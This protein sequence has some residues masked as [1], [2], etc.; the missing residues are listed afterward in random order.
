MDASQLFER[1][2]SWEKRQSLVGAVVGLAIVQEREKAFSRRRKL[3][4]ENEAQMLK[5]PNQISDGPVTYEDI[6][7]LTGESCG[8]N[9][10]AL[11]P[12]W[13]TS[14]QIKA[15]RRAMSRNVPN[16]IFF[17]RADFATDSRIKFAKLS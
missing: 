14:R 13:I 10:F 2:Q 3:E 9:S 8:S 17:N 4:G 15:G 5:Q 11:E 12:V 7:Q 16:N 6:K 1:R